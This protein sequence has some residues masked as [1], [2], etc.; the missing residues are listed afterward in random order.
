MSSH[1]L[2]LLHNGALPRLP[3]TCRENKNRQR[4]KIRCCQLRNVNRQPAKLSHIW[5]WSYSP[6]STSQL[7]LQLIFILHKTPVLSQCIPIGILPLRLKTVQLCQQCEFERQ[8]I[9]LLQ[10]QCR[11]MPA[12]NNTKMNTKFPSPSLQVTSSC[13]KFLWKG[14]SY[15][16]PCLF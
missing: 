1:S 8:K 4:L 10:F 6:S 15:H 13:F 5:P 11:N 14:F 3:S 12:P 7:P 9:V 16:L 2:H